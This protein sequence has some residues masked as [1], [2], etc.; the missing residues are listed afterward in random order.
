MRLAAENV[1]DYP[2][3]PRLE[4]VPQ[5]ICVLLGGETVA[6]TTRALR[7]LE[8]HHAPTYYLPPQ[9]IAA[10]LVPAGGGSFCEWKGRAR[11]AD[12]CAGGRRAPRAAWCYDAPS[13]PFDAL[14]GHYAIYAAAMDE[15]WVGDLR[16]QPQPGG[17]YGGWVTA[18]LTGRVKGAPGTEHR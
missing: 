5:R 3:P 12:V 16:A 7:V 13:P 15:V 1:Q 18:N 2:R 6:E 17:F 9:D 14:A 11:Y 4:T 8:T 10:T